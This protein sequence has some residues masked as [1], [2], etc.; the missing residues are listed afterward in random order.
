M[1]HAWR[2]KRLA[3][4]PRQEQRVLHTHPSAPITPA[5]RTETAHPNKPSSVLAGINT[6]TVR[7]VAQARCRE[8]PRPLCPPA[9]PALEG[10]S[11]VVRAV[12]RATS[13]A[14]DDLAFVLHHFLSA[15]QLHS[16]WRILRAK[17]LNRET[18]VRAARQRTETPN[19]YN[20]SFEHIDLRRLSK[21]QTSDGERRALCVAV[22][23]PLLDQEL[24]LDHELG[25]RQ[26]A[27]RLAR[28][29]FVADLAVEALQRRSA[30]GCPA[31]WWP[32]W[33]QA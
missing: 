16:I 26:S 6:K 29:Q 8:L 4:A 3:A 11:T 12:W 30:T 25:L 9:S 33:R 1:K 19:G 22:S 18:T 31:R 24:V 21:L 2:F 14:L 28:R 10:E 23:V 7:Q 15:S 32:V 20:L 5:T 13:L 27:G 17:G